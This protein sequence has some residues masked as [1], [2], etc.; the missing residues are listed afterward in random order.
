VHRRVAPFA[1]YEGTE[2]VRMERFDAIAAQYFANSDGYYLK[3]DTQGYEDRVLT[4]AEA[5]I[6]KIQG[7]QLELSLVQLYGGQ[8]LFDE[9][10]R[11][12]RE[13]G[14]ELHAVFP[15]FFD[16]SSGRLLQF[17]GVFF[18]PFKS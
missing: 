2:R 10:Y 13:L 18:R 14:F 3:I 7:I 5:L 9:M 8:P 6:E 15:E 16:Q 4:G 17:D 1:A 11:R 12:V